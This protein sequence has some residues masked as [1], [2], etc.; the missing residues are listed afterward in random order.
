MGE[1]AGVKTIPFVITKLNHHS[2]LISFQKFIVED[3]R[4][5]SMVYFSMTMCHKRIIGRLANI[6]CCEVCKGIRKLSAPA[7]VSYIKFNKTFH[8]PFL[9]KQYVQTLDWMVSTFDI[10]TRFPS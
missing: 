2:M 10:L 4:P 3:N 6:L 1:Y 9:N 8:L 7:E 5:L